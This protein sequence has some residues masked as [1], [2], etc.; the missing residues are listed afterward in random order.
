M[1]DFDRTIAVIGLGYVGLP[2]DAAFAQTYQPL[3]IILSDDCSGDRTFEIMQEMAAAY[4][5][6]HRV[7]ARQNSVNVGTALHLQYAFQESSG[8][9]FVVA[10]GD[11]VS[12]CDRVA[13]LA[14]AWVS[15][16]CPE[17]ILH[18]GRETFRDG[19]TVGFV[20]AKRSKY[21][22]RV[23]EGFA[24]AHWLPAA[25]PTCAYT[26]SVF[27]RF[28]PLIGGSIIEDAPL[29]LRAALLGRF[30]AINKPL[31]RHR[32]HDDNAGTGYGVGA[33]AR[34]NRFIQSKVI[35]F[36]TM[37]RDLANWRGEIDPAL[38]RR[39]ERQILKVLR[40]SSGLML[41]ETRSA[42]L[43]EQS[44]L[45]LRMA[46]SLAVA[47]SFRL[48]VEYLLSFFGFEAHVRLKDYIRRLT[49]RKTMQN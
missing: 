35:A 33:A 39:I 46:T 17:G 49:K 5:G 38:R 24:R 26:R 9:L 41:P 13:V 1:S 32:V 45:T 34:W 19:E 25:A 6:P 29:F 7:M 44:L 14:E 30:I 11:D 31:V 3:E 18:S 22:D 47:S 4:D 16:G 20:P 37:Q 2:L 48:R 12:T 8:E 28:A 42:G 23:L 27:E 15:A 40:S 36:R 10:A 43:L 21:S